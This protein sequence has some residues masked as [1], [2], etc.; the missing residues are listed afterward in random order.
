M[1]RLC[2]GR[3]QL[4][5]KGRGGPSAASIPW[6]VS[7]GSGAAALPPTVLWRF[8]GESPADLDRKTYPVSGDRDELDPQRPREPPQP[9]PVQCVRE[10]LAATKQ[11]RDAR[12]HRALGR[13]RE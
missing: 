12:V 9:A 8:I 10:D 6:R 13:R 5:L 11:R 2:A 3:Q 7:D 4:L 1:G